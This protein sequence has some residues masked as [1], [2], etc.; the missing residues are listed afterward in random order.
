MPTRYHGAHCLFQWRKL[1]YAVTNRM[2]FLDNKTVSMHVSD[3]PRAPVRAPCAENDWGEGKFGELTTCPRQHTKHCADQ[4]E[5]GCEG[6]HDVNEV[7]LGFYRCRKMA[8]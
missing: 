1:Q 2:D 7:E 8:W 5:R 6:P 3:P 4:L